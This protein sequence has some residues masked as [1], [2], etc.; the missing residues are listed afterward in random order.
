MLHYDEEKDKQV[1]D[2]II[3]GYAATKAEYLQMLAEYN[4]N[5]FDTKAARMKFMKNGQNE[6]IQPF[7]KIMP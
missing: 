5:P 6:N 2:Y 3:V 1:Q 4:N 7:L